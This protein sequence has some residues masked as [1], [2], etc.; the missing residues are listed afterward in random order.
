MDITNAATFSPIAE[1]DTSKLNAALADL[2]FDVQAGDVVSLVLVRDSKITIDMRPTITIDKKCAVEVQDKDGNVLLTEVVEPGDAFP[3]LPYA[4]ENGFYINGATEAVDTLPATVTE[5]MTV[6][7][8]GD[9]KIDAITLEK[10]DLRFGTGLSIDLYLRADAYAVAAGVATEDGTELRATKQEN[11]SFKITLT[12]IPVLEMGKDITVFPFQDFADGESNV[13]ATLTVN[14][15]ALLGAPEAGEEAICAAMLDYIAAADAYFNGATLDAEVEARLAAQDAAI[16][17]LAKDIERDGEGDYTVAR[18]TLVLKDTVA[19]KIGVE[20]VDLL[21]LEDDDLALTVR[22]GD[23]DYEGFTIQQGSENT[24]MVI[25]L[26]S[27]RFDDFAET[28]EITVMDGFTEM[29][30]TLTY[31]V[32]TYIARTFEGGAGETDN[33]LRAL[34]ALGVA[35]NA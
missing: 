25:T 22:V 26:G 34:Y 2:T 21:T 15:V 10:T 13:S 11:G 6:K 20:S 24:S 9:F 23:E 29:S 14:P 27:I 19:L 35:A 16:K 30:D 32:N 7:Y 18:A 31:S 17:A 5:S 8:A 33:L 4:S 28:V 3:A 12:D 1:G